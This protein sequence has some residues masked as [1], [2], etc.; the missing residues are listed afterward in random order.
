MKKLIIL[1]AFGSLLFSCSKEDNDQKD[2]LNLNLSDRL[3][4]SDFNEFQET[5]ATLAK[6]QTDDELRFWAQSKKHSTLLD[7]QDTVLYPNDTVLMKYSS[8]FRTILNNDFEFEIGEH[9]VWFNI[10]TGEL[11]GYSKN[12][13]TPDKENPDG[14]TKIGLIKAEKVVIPSPK[15]TGVAAG[16]INSTWQHE[17]TVTRYAP[18]GG[19]IEDPI[20][21]MRKW[22]VDLYHESI[23]NSSLR[24]WA[25]YLWLRI[26]LEERTPSINWRP[27]FNYRE[28]EFEVEGTA[29]YM[30]GYTTISTST[31]S[32]PGSHLGCGFSGPRNVFLASGTVVSS[33]QY[34]GFNV[35]MTGWIRQHIVG[36]NTPQFT[37][38]SDYPGGELY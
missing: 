34:P 28:L 27:C 6:Y 26:K 17:F 35:S 25:G 9:I 2:E 8:A 3:V 30:L 1:F 19:P 38:P 22:V 29:H 21:G 18:C 13:G 5:Y 7:L 10:N 37:F 20:S 12:G 23:Y 36:D 15:W 4:F 16:A 33:E 14:F 32:E 31:F 11:L 24:Q